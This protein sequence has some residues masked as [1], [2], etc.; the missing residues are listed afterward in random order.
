MLSYENPPK[1]LYY[2]WSM[3]CPAYFSCIIKLLKCI[4]VSVYV[5]VGELSLL[6]KASLLAC[7]VRFH[8]LYFPQTVK[9]VKFVLRKT[10][11][12]MSQIWRRRDITP[13]CYCIDCNCRGVIDLKWN[14]KG[15][16]HKSIIQRH[17]EEGDMENFMWDAVERKTNSAEENLH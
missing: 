8:L 13:T 14:I 16:P 3:H 4:G 5:H 6:I 15:L 11:D 12:K 10:G 7:L 17:I 9:V 2:Q 1:L